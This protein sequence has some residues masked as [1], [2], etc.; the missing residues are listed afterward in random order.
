MEKGGVFGGRQVGGG[1][2]GSR[3]AQKTRQNIAFFVSGGASGGEAAR[4]HQRTPEMRCLCRVS[5]VGWKGS[6]QTLKTRPCGCVLGVRHGR[7]A[8]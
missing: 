3:P 8:V 1:S 7:G 6:R 4:G 5:G 2:E